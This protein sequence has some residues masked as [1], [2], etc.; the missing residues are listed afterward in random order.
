[1]YRA[2]ILF[3]AITTLAV[4]TTPETA[5]GKKGKGRRGK[6]V[7]P[8]SYA[9]KKP[10]AAASKKEAAFSKKLANSILVGRF[11]IAGSENK[12]QP[13]EERY[14]IT[15]A[16]RFKGSMWIIQARV[17][18]GK[19]DITVPIPVTVRWAGDTPMISLTN[20]S[21]P[22]LGSAFS[23]RVLFYGDRYAG[24]WQHGKKGGHMWERL[25][26]KNQPTRKRTPQKR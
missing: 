12:K 21:I 18:Y 10:D 26:L 16:S 7:R 8:V 24:T 13:Q 22:G 17:K 14:E 5:W 3:V 6:N 15:K 1:M 23:C 2:M 19:V 9:N 11:S 20:A 25:N 4:A